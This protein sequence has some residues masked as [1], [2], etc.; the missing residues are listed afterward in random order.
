VQIP[1]FSAAVIAAAGQHCLALSSNG[2]LWSWGRN[3]NG[4]LG[5]GNTTQKSSP[6]LA[7]PATSSLKWVTLAGGGNGAHSVGIVTDPN[8]GPFELRSWGINAFGQLGDNTA[9]PHSSPAGLFGSF[10]L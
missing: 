1:S 6:F 9:T 10:G 4:Q 7:S 2:D 3:S 8:G 5:I